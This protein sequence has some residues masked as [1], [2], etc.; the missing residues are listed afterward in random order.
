MVLNKQYANFPPI[1]LPDKSWSL[2]LRSVVSLL[3]AG[4]GIRDGLQMGI[5]LA[6]GQP[7]VGLTPNLSNG[8]YVAGDLVLKVN[9]SAIS[10]APASVSN[11][12]MWFGLNGFYYAETPEQLMLG[13]ILRPSHDLFLGEISTNATAILTI[14]QPVIYG[15]CRFGVRGVINVS[16]LP[17]G[18]VPLIVWKKPDLLNGLN[19]RVTSA[20][21]T[22]KIAA[23]AGN[24]ASDNGV[25]KVDKIDGSSPTT[26]VT[27]TGTSIGAV[28][29][30]TASTVSPVYSDAVSGLVFSYNQTDADANLTGGLV[31]FKAVIEAI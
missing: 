16:E 20:L 28:G 7:T 19:L 25:L 8:H 24:A 31:E 30:S 21:L 5:P 18:D 26:L 4:H 27:Q 15:A 17:T 22:T 14:A 29:T 1:Q 12:K 6:S 10:A 23:S 13:E 9:P 2:E 11:R 3:N